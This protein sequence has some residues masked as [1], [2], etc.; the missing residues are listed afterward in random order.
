MPYISPCRRARASSL[1]SLL[2]AVPRRLSIDEAEE[3]DHEQAENTKA[4]TSRLSGFFRRRKSESSVEAEAGCTTSSSGHEEDNLLRTAIPDMTDATQ[5]RTSAEDVA[6]KR[7]PPAVGKDDYTVADDT[8]SA[9]TE[10]TG[11]NRAASPTRDCDNGDSCGSEATGLKCGREGRLLSLF[12]N[13]VG[14]CVKF[15]GL[16]D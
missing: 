11:S 15:T 14:E 9:T 7:S 5:C 6:V 13:R 12:R 10:A 4:N 3:R 16:L 1:P 8:A 2:N